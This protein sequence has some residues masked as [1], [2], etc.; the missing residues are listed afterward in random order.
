MCCSISLK[1]IHMG[2]TAGTI[3]FNSESATSTFIAAL[4][5]FEQLS[6]L[7]SYLV[8]VHVYQYVN[9]TCMFH[10]LFTFLISLCLPYSLFLSIVAS[11]CVMVHFNTY[12]V[13][14]KFGFDFGPKLPLANYG[15]E[16]TIYPKSKT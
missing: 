7:F 14:P 3:T 12:S 10:C 11:T 15:F 9:F 6:S 2:F 13:T 5:W 16:K 1:V 4:S 8:C